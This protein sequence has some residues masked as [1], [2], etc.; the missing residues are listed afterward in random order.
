MHLDLGPI[1][2]L[3]IAV[4]ALAGIAVIS[5]FSLGIWGFVRHTKRLRAERKSTQEAD[6][7]LPFSRHWPQPHAR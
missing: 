1:L 5:L 7:D 2:Y 4:E 3:L 6:T